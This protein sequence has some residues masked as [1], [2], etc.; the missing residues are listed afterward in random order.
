MT[1]AEKMVEWQKGLPC[2]QISNRGCPAHSH[3]CNK[4]CIL[5]EEWMRL[6]PEQSEVVQSTSK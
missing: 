2:R 6:K 3:E 1:Y 4:R 5:F